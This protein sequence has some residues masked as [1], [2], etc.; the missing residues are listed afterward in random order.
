MV[1]QWAV[2]LC[3]LSS[4]STL[5]ILLI[6]TH[7]RNQSSEPRRQLPFSSISVHIRHFLLYEYVR[8]PYDVFAT[9]FFRRRPLFELCFIQ[10][11]SYVFSTRSLAA[12]DS[13]VFEVQ[14]RG[15]GPAVFDFGNWKVLIYLPAPFR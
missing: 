4:L 7:N 5:V 1:R 11:F 10:D 15:N 9:H 13:Y 6:G 3:V 12:S 14:F 8:A 2:I